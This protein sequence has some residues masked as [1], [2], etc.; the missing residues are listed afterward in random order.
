MLKVVVPEASV[1][2]FIINVI[3]NVSKSPTQNVTQFQAQTM[4]ILKCSILIIL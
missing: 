1:R 4:Y 3:K 2:D